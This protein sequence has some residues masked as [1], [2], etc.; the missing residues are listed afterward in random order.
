MR[1]PDDSEPDALE[2][3]ADDHR[4]I[5]AM[6]DRY[7]HAPDDG[8]RLR[9]VEAICTELSIH[10]QLEEE[11]FYGALRDVL[12]E[13]RPID[14]AEVEHGSI[15]HI[16]TELREGSPE[17]RHYDANVRVLGAY[18]RHHVEEE[19]GRLF[20]RARAAAGIDLAEMGREMRHRRR[21]LCEER[22]LGPEQEAGPSAEQ[23]IHSADSRHL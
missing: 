13:E 20:P 17:S 19:Q 5:D 7:E 14:D 18:V 3:L 21:Q 16:V 11:L 2:L 4:R 8:Q 1:A 15:R 23:K 22:G 12:A 6:F 10:A 9:L